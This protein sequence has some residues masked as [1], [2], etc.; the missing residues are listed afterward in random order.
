MAG[1]AIK[2]CEL[3]KR[4]ALYFDEETSQKPLLKIILNSKTVTEYLS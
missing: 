1:I 3:V 2:E 4:P